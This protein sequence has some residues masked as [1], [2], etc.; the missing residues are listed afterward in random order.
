MPNV[1]EADDFNPKKIYDSL[2]ARCKQ[3]KVWNI[4]CIVDESFV[5]IA[6][7]DIIIQD[8]I[9]ICKVVAPSK[10]DALI[11]VANSLPVIKFFNSS[12]YDE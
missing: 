6:P 8:G 11:K 3:A 12:E 2:I 4:C 7:F 1:I 9:F 5:G 10:R